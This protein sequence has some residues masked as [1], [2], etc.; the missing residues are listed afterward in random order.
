MT[1]LIDDME[2]VF[3]LMVLLYA[4]ASAG[5]SAVRQPLEAIGEPANHC[6]IRTFVFL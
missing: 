6:D 1:D 5:S 4:F 3:P 2:S